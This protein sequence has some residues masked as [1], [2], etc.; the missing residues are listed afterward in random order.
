MNTLI[1]RSIV[2]CLL[3][4]TPAAA[5]GAAAQERTESATS[6][7]DAHLDAAAVA[8]LER[9]SKA[10]RGLPHFSLTSDASTEVVLQSGQ[11]IEL[12]GQIRYE[13]E[14][15]RRLFVD[16]K[17]DR[18]HRQ[19]FYDGNTLT[20]YSPRLKYYASTDDVHASLRELAG[21]L[22]TDYG[23][24]LPLVDLF[25][26][27][28]DAAPANVLTSA[29]YVGAGTLEGER[30]DHYAYQQPG[31]DWQVWISPSSFLPQ[32]IVITSLDDPALPK[33]TARLK[34]DTTR[35]I[36]AARYTFKPPPGS[37]RI[38]L[39]EIDAVAVQTQEK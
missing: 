37:A 35:A 12:D 15:P 16:I 19:L 25:L 7:Q 20:L 4:A 33:Y 6:R 18:A 21:T 31:A 22:S 28:T 26:W 5:F 1:S 10:L 30:V 17:S 9:M 13:V 34:W 2:A 23:I 36:A 3:A 24:D 27:G 14:P 11:K 38:T 32:K 39:V 8:A 29:I